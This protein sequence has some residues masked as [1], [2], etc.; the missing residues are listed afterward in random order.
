MKPKAKGKTPEKPVAATAK[1]KKRVQVP[2][3]KSSLAGKAAATPAGNPEKKGI[4][5]ARPA[6]A[7]A[8]KASK[9][10][11]PAAKP[12][13][14]AEAKPA[15]AG[16][17]ATGK[18]APVK[19][20]SSRPAVAKA[21]AG[22]AKG[23][24]KKASSAGKSAVTGA[25]KPVAKASP[26]I[27]PEKK[28]ASPAIKS[29]LER[30][31]RATSNRAVKASPPAVAKE[32]KIASRG[33]TS[34]EEKSRLKAK[35]GAADRPLPPEGKGHAKVGASREKSAISALGKSGMKSASTE[36]NLPRSGK[37]KTSKSVEGSGPEMAV[38]TASTTRKS[39]VAPMP[40]V[41]SQAAVP[42]KAKIKAE[43]M[44]KLRQMLEEERDS[45]LGE[46]RR[47]DD[48]SLVEGTTEEGANQQP[49]FSLQLADSASDNLQIETDLNIRRNEE[50][51]LQ[52]IEDA[53][54]SLDRG[55]FGICNRCNEPIN[56]ER[57]F[58]RPNAKYCM[59][60]LRL[61]ES[62]KA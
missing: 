59:P 41:V 1:S 10:S 9:S 39:P 48:R 12:A 18:S 53:L 14:R 24:L 13:T 28:K 7:G 38:R 26:A 16:G 44:R 3:N 11:Q 34:V 22:S 54:R 25:K 30:K 52:Q 8:G 29:P 31:S 33:A 37:E 55:E 58:A 46:L 5:A 35:N 61:L 56:I 32:A 50:Q 62:G 51:L 47:L 60:C 17:K 43:D 21:V 36:G 27:R 49:G 45:L 4:G 23:V 15:T 57:L 2:D 40:D 42:K 20:A 19:G 6:G